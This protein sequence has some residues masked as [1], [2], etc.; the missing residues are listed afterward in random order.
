MKLSVYNLAGQKVK[1][2]DVSEHIFGATVKP[3]VVHQAVI[4]QQANA[5]EPTAHTKNRGE[6]SGGGKKP[7]KQKGTGRARQG[8]T[9]SPLWRH[10]GVVFGPRND[11]NYT[12]KLNKKQKQLAL[13]MCLS[14]KVAANSFVVFEKLETNGKAKE[15]NSWV[16][17]M[18]GKIEGLNGSRKPLLILDHNDQM[19]V[20]AALNLPFVKTITADSLNCLM[21]LNSDKIL[22]SEGALDVIAKHYT[23]IPT[24]VKPAKVKVAKVKTVKKSHK[25]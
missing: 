9:R 10:G 14:D 18:I 21:L 6:V 5:H 11:K 23:K 22:A 17:E 8:S 15:L 2:K 25:K 1:D 3:E 20:K 4:A 13:A 19:M 7:W 24:K 12:Q 16:N